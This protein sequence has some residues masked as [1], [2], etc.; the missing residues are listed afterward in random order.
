MARSLC[1][2]LALGFALLLSPALLVGC[3]EETPKPADTAAP[4][5]AAASPGGPADAKP[6]T[7]PAT[8]APK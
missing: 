5:P 8:P 6:A 4:A 7:P 1:T 3:S 2:R